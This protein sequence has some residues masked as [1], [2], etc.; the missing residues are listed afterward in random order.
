MAVL[1]GLWVATIVLAHAFALFWLLKTWFLSKAQQFASK[2]KV[3]DGKCSRENSI[4]SNHPLEA[5]SVSEDGSGPPIGSPSKK[6]KSVTFAPCDVE[7]A[8]DTHHDQASSLHDIRAVVNAY[9]SAHAES[10]EMEWRDIGCSYDINGKK[11]VVLQGIYG[12]AHPAEMHVSVTCLRSASGA[13]SLP[14]SAAMH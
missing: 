14:L 1:Y 12:S 9:P 6:K 3:L 2:S 10:Y 13:G 5:D 7:A 11:K 8:H 4:G